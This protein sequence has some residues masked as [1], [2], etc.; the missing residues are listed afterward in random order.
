MERLIALVVI[1]ALALAGGIG[2]DAAG[3]GVGDA[4]SVDN[5]TISPSSG[6]NTVSESNTDRYYFADSATVYNNSTVVPADGNYTWNENNG[7]LTVDSGSYLANRA[8]ANLSFNYS[9]PSSTERDVISLFAGGV[10]IMALLP[11]VLFIGVL[12]AAIRVMA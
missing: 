5:R 10:E 12:A 6:L 9:V 1:A 4:R 2:I 11:L 7:T 3:E 8:S